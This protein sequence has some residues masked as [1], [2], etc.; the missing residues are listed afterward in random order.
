M[1]AKIPGASASVLKVTAALVWSP[2]VASMEAVPTLVISVGIWAT[3]CVGKARS[4]GAAMPLIL[5][6]A[7]PSVVTTLPSGPELV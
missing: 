6:L 4:S 2:T 1:M 7:P 3:S 5:T